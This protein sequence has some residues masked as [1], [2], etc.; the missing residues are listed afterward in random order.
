MA[1]QYKTKIIHLD[2]VNN[3]FREFDN[4]EKISKD[5]PENMSTYELVVKGKK[6][7][8]VVNGSK[9]E[10][11]ICGQPY[12]NHNGIKYVIDNGRQNYLIRSGYLV[13]GEYDHTRYEE[14]TGRGIRKRDKIMDKF[15]N[16]LLSDSKKSFKHLEKFKDSITFTYE[17]NGFQ[18]S[19]SI[20]T[21]ESLVRKNNIRKDRGL[22]FYPFNKDMDNY[23][24]FYLSIFC[25]DVSDKN[26]HSVEKYYD[27][28]QIVSKLR[29]ILAYII[30]ET[31]D[32]LVEF[33]PVI[34][35]KRILYYNEYGVED[36]KKEA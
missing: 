23:M 12:F 28:D 5:L 3:Y 14:S 16:Y 25:K 26:M 22:P 2:G 1:A 32:Q 27:A 36:L 13:I 35:K 17:E 21:I 30:N 15:Y 4:K 10:F 18:Y 29:E 19:V 6:Y 8:M 24:T 31:D 20:D 33:S 9:I 7:E 34:I 11:N